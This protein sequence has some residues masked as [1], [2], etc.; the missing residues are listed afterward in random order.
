MFQRRPNRWAAF[1]KAKP[2]C[3]VLGRAHVR[4]PQS[5]KG[6]R[7]LH[8]REK[9]KTRQLGCFCSPAKSLTCSGSL[10]TPLI[11]W[12]KAKSPNIP[13]QSAPRSILA[14]TKTKKKQKRPRPL[15]SCA[16][17]IPVLPMDRAHAQVKA[18]SG[19]ACKERNRSQAQLAPGSADP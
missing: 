19:L 16:D 18:P 13:W 6:K 14:E 9:D 11:S 17:S 12:N 8:K 10:E 2:S 7:V 1:K 5:Q 15:A 4:N 3:P